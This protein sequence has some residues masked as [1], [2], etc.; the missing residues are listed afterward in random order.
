[1]T[2]PSAAPPTTS[3]SHQRR[4]IDSSHRSPPAATRDS[5]LSLV[6]RLIARI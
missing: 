5:K 1:M 4:I 3:R 6:S 2:I